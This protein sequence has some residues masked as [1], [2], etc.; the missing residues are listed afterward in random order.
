MAKVGDLPITH[1]CAIHAIVAAHLNLISQL[2][3]IPALCE[4]VALVVR[5]R[6]TNA[7]YYLPSM[8]F[9]RKNT[10]KR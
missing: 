9:N 3:G 2:T 5:R 8:A 10:A 1:K 6:N 7:P 4:H